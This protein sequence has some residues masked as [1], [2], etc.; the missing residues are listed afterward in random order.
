LLREADKNARAI[1]KSIP[2]NFSSYSYPLPDEVFLQKG[3]QPTI[4]T[5]SRLEDSAEAVA[6]LSRPKRPA[7]LVL[8]NPRDLKN[9]RGNFKNVRK[10]IALEL[11][12][13]D[14]LRVFSPQIFLLHLG[15][16]QGVNE[17]AVV[18]FPVREIDKKAG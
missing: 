9:H 13:R 4:V 8:P 1:G 6:A 3:L 5:G 14:G 17:L 7:L 12:E 18:F 15:Q 10:R 16:S 2:L 11:P